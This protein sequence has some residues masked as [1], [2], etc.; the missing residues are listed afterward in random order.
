MLDL[1][2]VSPLVELPTIRV[3]TDGSA[4]HNGKSHAIGGIG[5]HFPDGERCDVS[6]PYTGQHLLIDA[7]GMS[8]TDSTAKGGK[9]TNQRAELEAIRV[10]I[11]MI[12]KLSDYVPKEKEIHI[13]TDSEY[14]IKALTIW[15][16]QWVDSNWMKARGKPVKNQDIIRP[17]FE[18]MRTHRVKFF[19]VMSHTNKKDVRS[20]G[21]ARADELATRATASVKKKVNLY[22]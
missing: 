15:V 14:S 18:L 7:Y 13:Y 16:Y 11:E 9:A 22:K 3:F 8:F 2:T 19:H 6:V 10:A 20:L 4:K 1:N 21:N 17:L 12:A 5:I